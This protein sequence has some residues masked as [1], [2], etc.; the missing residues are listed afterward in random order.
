MRVHPKKL[1]LHPAADSIPEMPADEYEAFLADVR[2]N[3]IRQP[4]ETDPGTTTVLDGRT[5]LKAA[6]EAGLSEVQVVDAPLGKDES[7]VLY[8][9]RAA[10]LRRH[11]TSGDRAILAA[12]IAS[13][14]ICK[15]GSAREKTA[16]REK[17]AAAAGLSPRTVASAG[18]VLE[19]GTP[20]E[21]EAVKKGEVA[22]SRAEK[23][24]RDKEKDIRKAAKTDPDR[25]GDLLEKLD[26]GGKVDPIHRELRKREKA[27]TRKKDVLLDQLERPVPDGL[28]DL[29]GDP[30]LGQTAEAVEAVVRDC[31]K[32]VKSAVE[33]KGPRY[34]FLLCGEI[35]KHLD[36]ARTDLE[37]VHSH[38]AEARP[39]AVCPKC[40]GKGC[41]LCRD[42][43]WLPRWRLKELKAGG[44]L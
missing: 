36:S 25:F 42:A 15:N 37:I 19:K 39:H 17:A 11:L 33:R 16:L 13:L 32:R 24:I 41:K 23:L 18:T 9:K 38:L 30:W 34:K 40:E 4:I 2:E 35:L 3:G 44:Q 22:P 28:R 10:L 6:L 27:G 1:T 26:A 43:G 21:V 7:P 14:Q 29:F 5:R 31:L 8:M 20:E 12:E